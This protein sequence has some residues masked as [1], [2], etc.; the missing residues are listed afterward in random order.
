A[1]FAAG[2][3]QKAV[4]EDAL[5]TGLF[6]RVVR[7]AL[8][9]VPG[10][11][12]P[13]DPDGLRDHV[14]RRF[15]ELIA[16]GHT[17]QVPSYLVYSPRAGSEEVLHDARASR[18]GLGAAMLPGRRMLPYE[19]YEPLKRILDAAEVPRA[20]RAIYREVSRNLVNLPAPRYPDDLT[21]TVEALRNAVDE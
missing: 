2:P 15:A 19:E 17:E 4:N 11:V 10:G 14:E 9:A 3:G 5:K 13:P 20:V 1:L 7:E 8:D 6:S 16:D 21:S 12:W 18:P